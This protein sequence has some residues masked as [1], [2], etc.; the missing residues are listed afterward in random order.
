M[1]SKAQRAVTGVPDERW[2]QF[3]KALQD[4]RED[5]LGYKVR[6]RFAA[7]RLPLTEEGNVNTK[8]V[9]EL[10]NNY[11]PGTYTKWSLEAAEKAY[12]ITH[13]S[14]L[15]FLHGEV[16]SLARAAAV[17]PEGPVPIDPRA[18]PP[19][20]FDPDKTEADRPYALAIWDRYLDLPR[21]VTQPSGEQMF[22]GSPDDARAWDSITAAYGIPAEDLVWAV[23]DLRRRA[24]DRD[25]GGPEANSHGA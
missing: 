10:E 13:E 17:S 9:Q 22:P 1:P 7:E 11:R 14:V 16:D 24:A 23:A 6:H 21:R 4:W 15:A 12:G 18:L 19:S 25:A 3:G 2:A 5:V 20:P 8:L